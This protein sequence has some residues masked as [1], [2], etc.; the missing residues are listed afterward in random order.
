MCSRQ[1]LVFVSAYRQGTKLSKDFIAYF[2]MKSIRIGGDGTK[3]L[4][5]TT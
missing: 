4:S 5:K 2:F 1:H 3:Y